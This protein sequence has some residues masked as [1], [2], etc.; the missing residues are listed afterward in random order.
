MDRRA[1]TGC[2]PP[3]GG[4]EP[5]PRVLVAVVALAV[6]SAASSL[7]LPW[8]HAYASAAAGRARGEAISSGTSSSVPSVRAAGSGDPAEL[9]Y[10]ADTLVLW[11]DTLVPGNYLA[12]NGIAP[13]ALA[14]DTGKDEIFVVDYGDGQSSYGPNTVRVLDDRTNAVLATVCVGSLPDG[15]AYDS[16]YGEVFVSNSGSDN[17][18]VISDATNQVV[19]TVPVGTDPAGIAYDPT[20]GELF[21]A[22]LGSDTLS[23]ISDHAAPSQGWAANTV[24]ATIAVGAGPQGVGYDSATDDLWV[25]DSEGA[26]VSV[27]S[28]ASSS[29]VAT[30]PVGGGP[31][32]VA[33]DGGTGQLFVSNP[34]GDYVSVLDEL[35]PY[36]LAATVAANA[37]AGLA[38]DSAQHAVYV[39]EN[40]DDDQVTEISDA[41]DKVVGGA[42]VGRFPVGVVYDSGVQGIYVANAYSATVS[43]L[44]GP[45]NSS[46]S[47]TIV[48]GTVPSG[49]AWDYYTFGAS[50][51]YVANYDG[52]TVYPISTSTGLALP[53]ISV[54]TEPLG[55]Y[56]G[57]GDVW[58][59]NFGSS[60]VSEIVESSNSLFTTYDVGAEPTSL[61]LYA[62]E[63][64]GLAVL[65]VANE[66]SNNVSSFVSTSTP[67]LYQ[68]TGS[69]SVTDPT[70][71]AAPL[72]SGGYLT[73]VVV[74]AST[75]SLALVATTNTIGVGDGPDG[76]AIAATTAVDDSAYVANAGS[77][78]VTVVAADG[79]NPYLTVAANL[80]VGAAPAGVAWDYDIGSEGDILVDNFGSD[81]V[82]VISVATN[83]LV[84]SVAVGAEPYGVAYNGV[85][86]DVLVTN[87]LQGTVSVLSFEPVGQAQ[88][89]EQGLPSGTRWSVTYD[90]QT[91]NSTAGN[92][93]FSG[94]NGTYDYEVAS[95]P[96]YAAIPVTGTIAVDGTAPVTVVHFRPVSP[97]VWSEAG[98]PV[99][100]LRWVVEVNG[101]VEYVNG[102][103]ATTVVLPNGT[104]PYVL[105]GPAGYRVASP[106]SFGELEVA[107]GVVSVNGAPL[108][109]VTFVKGSTASVR[110]T[111]KGLAVGRSW[112]VE[113]QG[114]PACSRS[115]KVVYANLTPGSY[116]YAVVAPTLG[117][118]VTASIDGAGAPASGTVHLVRST[119]IAVR[120]AYEYLVTFT[121]AGL[122]TGSWSVTVHGT[123]RSAPAGFAIYFELPNGSYAYAIGRE[124]GASASGTP[125]PV[126]VDGGPAAVAVTFRSKG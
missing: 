85:N 22:N 48:V 59:A 42:T 18:S 112:C 15:A 80:P 2:R 122:A 64:S 113:L 73:P 34:E 108:G 1:R 104:Y 26:S 23:V 44:L 95:V 35:P 62:P 71:L 103:S 121:E 50:G 27:V 89:V 8:D 107:G 119:T 36:T 123:T 118:T 47:A 106:A 94:S 75:D 7:A 84:G 46:A 87:S 74:S 24:V 25:A 16:R 97:V 91:R 79:G 49:V 43:E 17:V 54:G 68:P 117:Q 92:L 9:P 90:G 101:T 28:A 93:S 125:R 72:F 116:S 105:A 20:D 52:G 31:F 60:N 70:S 120:F 102:S 66:G 10:V 33:Y 65:E 29:L 115:G 45:L 39:A 51:P 109:T 88:F 19:A 30:V 55:L 83:Q 41:T 37:P 100:R 114:W 78:N 21:V 12:S 99:D 111:E 76:V 32:G 126:P 11:N 56:A 96:G 6:L 110:F 3:R 53:P 98:L 124:P 67:N 4:P 38:Y 58:S 13:Y 69:W 57:G 63:H 61:G 82:S 5:S 77:D 81:N 86:N 14:Y 40:Y